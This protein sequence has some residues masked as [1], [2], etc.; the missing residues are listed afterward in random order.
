[1]DWYLKAMS[2]PKSSLEE[3]FQNAGFLTRP[4][5][6]YGID[7]A[8]QRGEVRGSAAWQNENTLCLEYNGPDG[9][10]YRVIFPSLVL[11]E[12]L[13]QLRGLCGQ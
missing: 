13:N 5:G 3:M 2:M 7:F 4:V 8:S 6:E 10:Q 1:M 9:C 12:K 11:C